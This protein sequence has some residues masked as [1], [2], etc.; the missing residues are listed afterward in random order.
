MAK[1]EI[2]SK[3][4]Q[5]M[6]E[7][8]KE[9]DNILRNTTKETLK[10]LVS[11]RVGD[12]LKKIISEAD[13]DKDDYDEEDVDD[14]TGSDAATT[15]DTDSS[16]D[17]T[18]DSD[19]T[20]TDDEPD[21]LPDPDGD[22]DDADDSDSDDGTEDDSDDGTDDSDTEDSDDSYDDG[23]DGEDGGED[24]E[25]DTFDNLP[26]DD[27]GEIDLTGMKPE[28]AIKVLKVMK[29]EDGIRVVKNDNGT[30]TVNDENNDAE[31]VI[32]VDGSTDSDGNEDSGDDRTFDVSIDT[33]SDTD[34]CGPVESVGYTDDYQ[35]KTAMTTLPNR[36]VADTH[37]T[38]KADYGVPEGDGKP[39]A[40]RGDNSP[41]DREVANEADETADAGLTEQDGGVSVDFSGEP[42]TNEATTVGGYNAQ[43]ST[44]KSH[45][46]NSSGR[47][48]RNMSKGG[49]YTG[50]AVP[51]YAEQNESIND[52]KRKANAIYEE[53]RQLKGL[54]NVFQKRLTEAAVVNASLGNI[55]KLVMEN[56][57]T[58]DEKKDIIRR[59]NKVRTIEEGK[60]L[61]G[62]ISE[63]LKSVK[64]VNNVQGVM[65]SQLQES[66]AR[67]KPSIVETELY[68]S[69]EAADDLHQTLD[70]M[71][72]LD[73][74]S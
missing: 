13:D 1:S 55:V 57:T 65:D 24:T 49:E 10:D 14:T 51:R 48:A 9:A 7:S 59:Y 29:P 21:E 20:S 47:R 58:Q 53:Y 56:T 43:N 62:V 54:V 27:D 3:F 63:E 66:R 31:Y 22:G 5:E 72:R 2:R 16:D 69:P 74:I 23:T 33:D 61:Y 32:D 73:K 42:G 52:I 28:D 30:I 38:R 34:E 15:D 50:T 46:P 25:D 39:W 71:K 12:S 17:S 41:Y 64:R 37:S 6:L 40:P 70:F 67:M 26:T 19:S 45:V 4:V 18:T 35:S 36:E 8:K 68:R 11:E 60:Q 44:A